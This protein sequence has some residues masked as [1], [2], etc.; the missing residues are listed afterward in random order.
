MKRFNREFLKGMFFMVALLAIFMTVAADGCT[1][2]SDSRTAETVKNQ[3][4][5]YDINQPIHVYQRSQPRDSLLAIYD[6]K[7]ESRNTW[8]VVQSLT[9]KLIFQ[10]PSV[11]YPLPGGT[12]LTNPQ[13]WAGTGLALAQP[14]PDGTYTDPNTDST[15][16]L[17]SRKNGKVSP[18]YTEAKV[19]AFPFPV[20]VDSDGV[21]HDLDQASSIEINVSTKF[22][23]PTNAVVPTPVK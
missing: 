17:C 1:S 18:V 5:I 20:S 22:A 16:V 2:T 10:C 8:S 19:S 23:P 11:G 7:V 15:Y 21:I 12:Q 3:Q 13:Y 9:G 6:A 14:E 4:N